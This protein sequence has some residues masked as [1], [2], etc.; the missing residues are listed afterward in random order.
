MGRAH[1]GRG[2]VR[3]RALVAGMGALLA[4]ERSLTMTYVS[5]LGQ[6]TTA[7]PP[8][9]VARCYELSLTVPGSYSELEAT[10]E[11]WIATCV[12]SRSP[13][14]APAHRER[15]LVRGNPTLRAVWEKVKDARGKKVTIKAD[16]VWGRFREEAVKFSTPTAFYDFP[17]ED[18]TIAPKPK[19][20]SVD[21]IVKRGLQLLP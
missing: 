4:S 8:R 15:E 19:P 6:A 12:Q 7:W 21:R 13:A 3:R 10:V 20:D 17:P 11:R 5:P 9:L 16:W 14:G 2:R 18:V 1:A